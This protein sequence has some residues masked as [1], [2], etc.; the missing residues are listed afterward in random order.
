MGP[1]LLHMMVKSGAA[2]KCGRLPASLALA[3]GAKLC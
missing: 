2:V 1:A 3:V